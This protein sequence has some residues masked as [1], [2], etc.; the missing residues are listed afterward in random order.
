[1]TAD[2]SKLPSAAANNYKIDTYN[3]K[4]RFFN[5]HLKEI[6]NLFK[7]LNQT[8]DELDKIS[9]TNPNKSFTSSVSSAG[10]LNEIEVNSKIVRKE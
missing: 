1:M 5:S 2:T 6:N 7:Q 4:V 3:N 9:H 10:L 8:D